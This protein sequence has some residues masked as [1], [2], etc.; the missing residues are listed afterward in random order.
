MISIATAIDL[1]FDIYSGI[2]VA[3]MHTR[4][5]YCSTKSVRQ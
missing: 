1:R 2:Q 4:K 5:L 3:E